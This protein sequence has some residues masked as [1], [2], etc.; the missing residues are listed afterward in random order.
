MLSHWYTLKQF[1]CSLQF[2]MLSASSK[3]IE[4]SG[5][6]VK[7]L[8]IE[9]WIP[10]FFWVSK[11][12]FFSSVSLHQKKHVKYFLKKNQNFPLYGFTKFPKIQKISKHTCA[13]LVHQTPYSDISCILLN[14]RIFQHT[15][16]DKGNIQTIWD[17][18]RQKLSDHC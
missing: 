13:S 10:V 8:V 14:S 4:C 1:L 11:L 12:A 3:S 16:E 6:I 2:S 9:S 17:I 15:Q 18:S 7:T 5:S